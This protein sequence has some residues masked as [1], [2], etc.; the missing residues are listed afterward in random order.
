MFDY[1]RRSLLDTLTRSEPLGK[2]EPAAEWTDEFLTWAGQMDRQRPRH[3]HPSPGWNWLKPGL[4]EGRLVGGCI[5]S[6][7]HLRGTRYWPNWQDALFFWETSEDKPTPETVDGMLMDYENMGMLAQIRGMLVG[8]PML[9]SPEEKQR[10][11]EVI[12]ER[13]RGYDFP[14]VTGMDFGHTSPQMVMPIGVLARVDS[15]REEFSILEPCVA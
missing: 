7:Q 1:A 12:L 11:D 14:V 2:V 4:G 3:M 8:R 9:Y 5:E 10:L 6:L 13:T 15:W